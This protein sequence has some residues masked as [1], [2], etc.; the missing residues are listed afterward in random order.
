MLGMHHQRCFGLLPTIHSLL[1]QA[2]YRAV[3]LAA[4]RSPRYLFDGVEQGLAAIPLLFKEPDSE[5][6]M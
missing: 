5:C 2:H 6:E 1:K 4:L 3:R